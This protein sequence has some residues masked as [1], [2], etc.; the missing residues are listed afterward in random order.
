MQGRLC[1]TMAELA[2][3]DALISSI[4]SWLVASLFVY[5]AA[6]F[7]LDRSSVVA[8]LLSVFLGSLLA[9]LVR[10]GADRLDFPAWAGL[11]LAFAAVALLI[12]VFFRTDWIKGAIIGVVAAL[13]WVLTTYLVG[14]LF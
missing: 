10:I 11:A 9:G 5:L 1:G 8:A 2:I 4:V 3:S 6:R 13:L 7:V 14:L 12:A